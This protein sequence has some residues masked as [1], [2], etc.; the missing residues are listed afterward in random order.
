MGL[1]M[2]PE[3]QVD[4]LKIGAVLNHDIESCPRCGGAH[5]GVQFIEMVQ[6]SAQATH[7]AT[8]P[9]TEEPILAHV[10]EIF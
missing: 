6:K 7:W 3:H 9:A 1:G 10:R 2:E 5:E 8:C 4:R